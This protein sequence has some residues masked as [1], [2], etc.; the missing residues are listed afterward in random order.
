MATRK[1]AAK[2]GKKKAQL[3]NLPKKSGLTRKQAT[4]VKA[5]HVGGGSGR[6]K[7]DY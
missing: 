7:L 6:T 1:A 4:A 5:G 2:N 3:R